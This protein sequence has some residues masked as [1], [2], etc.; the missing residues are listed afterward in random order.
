MTNQNGTVREALSE[1]LAGTGIGVLVGLLI[2]L[3]V[4]E[5]VGAVVGGLMALL[6][7]FLGL[8]EEARPATTQGQPLNGP[9]LRAWRLTGFGLVCS[10]AILAGLLI[11]THN[12]LSR[13]PRQ[14]VQTWKDAG[15]P[16]KT[17]R[18]LAAYQELGLV[19]EGWKPIKVEGVAA[20][21]TS[22]LFGTESASRCGELAPSR[23]SDAKE[24]AYAFVLSGSGWKAIGETV[25]DLEISKQEKLLD[26]TWKLVCEG[27]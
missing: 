1:M 9:A 25:R 24:R 10:V 3:S 26:A 14:L 5:V 15:Y 2:G 23:F 6:A 17:A 21:T 12:L 16:D 8:K 18:D 19:T 7:A 11:R 13:T 20:R 27:E 4:S 22:S